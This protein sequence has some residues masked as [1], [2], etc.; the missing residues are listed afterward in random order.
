MADRFWEQPIEGGPQPASGSR[1]DIIVV[2]GGPG[3]AAAAGYAALAGHRVLLLDKAIWPRD[4]TCGDAVGGKS[5]SHVEELG[6]LER[7]EA[8]PHFK[9]TGVL[10]SSPRGDEIRVS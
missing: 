6:V 10:F 4:K 3:G 5:L 1:F 9:I 2:G 8:S 7:L